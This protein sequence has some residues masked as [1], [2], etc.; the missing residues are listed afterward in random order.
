MQASDPHPF[1]DY[2]LDVTFS[3]PS[4]QTYTVPGFYAGDGSGGSSGNKWQT[5]FAPDEAGD[6]SYEAS[7][8]TGDNVAVSGSPDADGERTGFD[9]A[10]G[11]FS[12]DAT[13]KTKP[14]LRARGT[15]ANRGDH[16]LTDENGEVFLQS[17]PNIPENFLG[18]QHFSNMPEA[19]KEYNSHESDWNSGDPKINGDKGI[20]GALNFIADRGANSIYFLPMNLGG[21]GEDT[22]PFPA[23][24]QKTRYDPEKLREWETVF[25]HAESRGILLH[26]VLSEHETANQT[27]FD[28]GGVGP[29]R[30]LFF[31]EL[32]ARF[33]HH[34]GVVWNIGE[35]AENQFDDADRE[36]MAA[37]LDDLE[38]YGH[39]IT[40]HN[41]SET[42]DEFDNF[43]GDGTLDYAALQNVSGFFT[44]IPTGINEWRERSASNGQPWTV[45]LTEPQK[46]ENND[47]TSVGKPYGRRHKMWPAF[48]GGAA[49]FE[50][51]IQNDGGGHSLDQNIE[52]FNRIEGPIRWSGVARDILENRTP[53]TLL[54]MDY[55]G[56]VSGTEGHYLEP[57]A[58][59]GYWVV[60]LPDGGSG[61]IDTEGKGDGNLTVTWFDPKTG[62][63]VGTDDASGGAFPA[64]PISGDVVGIIS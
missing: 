3:G 49:S 7:F 57:N 59:N 41:W 18:Y 16:Y 35:E 12:V 25:S 37:E 45:A 20:I 61:S 9:G 40:V 39:P 14:D 47:D 60:A 5:R 32:I 6:W 19:S 36:A 46:I 29:Q 15:I 26:F 11:S 55:G 54:G 53:E 44:D 58:G 2:R 64:P 22:Y 48:M 23:P 50:W 1:L 28:N 52:D 8:W 24:D 62:D 10:T 63:Q 27:F 33:G 21:D 31:R 4:G 30:K 17:G 34:A 51:Y 43:L 42:E 38:P 13:D 56:T